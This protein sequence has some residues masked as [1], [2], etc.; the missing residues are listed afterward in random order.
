MKKLVPVWLILVLVPV[1]VP[2]LGRAA[3]P[4]PDDDARFRR[5][6]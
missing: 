2:L 1:V 5:F 6:G 4:V 3:E